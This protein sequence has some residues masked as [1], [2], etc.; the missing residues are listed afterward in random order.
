MALKEYS[1]D[2]NGIEHTMRLSE[3]D[4]K[5]YGEAAKPVNKAEAKSGSKGRIP[6]NKESKPVNKAEAKTQDKTAAA[7]GA[8]DPGA[9][10][11]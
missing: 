9:S 11:A 5:R 1:V 6:Q 4:A 2:I 7:D 8:S 10:E 3:S